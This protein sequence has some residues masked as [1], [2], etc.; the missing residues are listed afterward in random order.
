MTLSWKITAFALPLWLAGQSLEA[1]LL[2]PHFVTPDF[3]TNQ[4]EYEHWE[5]S[6]WDKFY[7]PHD[8]N[9]TKPQNRNYPDIAAPNGYAVEHV[10]SDDIGPLG[11]VD[12]V[13]PGQYAYVGPF[14]GEYIWTVQSHAEATASGYTG[15]LPTNLNPS[16][17]RTIFHADN[18]SIRQHSSA[19]FIIGPGY[20]GNIYS[21]S[22]LV[23]YTLED[24]LSY[25]A[26][27][28]VFQ[29]Q[30]QG[31]D[32]DMDS[33]RLRYNDGTGMV[34]VPAT[35]LIIEREAFASHAGFTFTTR[36]AA[37]WN[38]SALGITNY[39][40]V[41][42]AAGTSCS[43]QECL[44][45]TADVY[46]RDKGLPAK[47]IFAGTGGSS[48]D[49]G[50]NW[51]DVAGNQ[52]P[53][54][55]GAN[56]VLQGGTML[57][58]G[59]TT[60]RVSLLETD[61]PGNF[62]V[63]GA[64][65]I[66]LGTGFHANGSSTTKFVSFDVPVQMT[67]FNYFD[68]GANVTVA[69]N[70]E[71]SGNTGFE[72]R[73]AGN[74][75]LAGNNTF[76]GALFVSG[77]RLTV[78]GNNV[79]GGGELDMTYIYLGELVLEGG[80]VM[81]NNGVHVAIGSTPYEI[82]GEATPS[83]LVVKGERTFVNPIDFTGGYNP[84]LLTFT[85]TG[86]GAVC[87]APVTLHDGTELGM[88]GT[89][90][91]TGEFWLDTPLATDKVTFAGTFTG[92][93]T[94]TGTPSPHALHKTGPGTVVFSGG[95]KSHKHKTSVEQGTLRLE[96]GTAINSGNGVSVSAGATFTANGNV[97]LTGSTLLVDGLL[98]GSGAL[99]RTGGVVVSGGGTIAK[100][101]TIDAG[102]TLSP[103]NGIGKL[104]LVGNQTW[105]AAGRL[106]LEVGGID[107]AL[108][109]RLEIQGALAVTDTS[110][111]PFTIELQ[112]LNLLSTAG[113]VADFNS[114]GH[115][116]WTLCSASSGITGFNAAAFTVNTTG[117]AHT[118]AGTFAVEQRVNDIVLV[119]TP[120]SMPSP[121]Y[122]AWAA[123]LPAGVRG[124]N[125]DADH[126]GLSNL[127][128]FALGTSGAVADG[129]GSPLR[130]R[131]ETTGG[132]GQS[133]L[134]FTR[135]E[136]FRPGVTVKLLASSTLAPGNWQT[137]ATKSGLSAWQ[138]T[139]ET[140]E[141]TTAAGRKPVTI[142]VADTTPDGAK[143]FFRLQFRNEE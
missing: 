82:P 115:H 132:V 77:G 23:S 95:N 114:Y 113:P 25:N 103:G 1:Q 92:G 60:R 24:S 76:T 98:D 50:V 101:L 143:R 93:A 107:P 139:G 3:S 42:K 16:L 52:S 2:R 136:P 38:V 110:G 108:H 37:E 116:A 51:R 118:L 104:T 112:S 34:E 91:P 123:S 111:T 71:F 30:N 31:R 48:W 120:S 7:T 12:Q 35:D 53:P 18:P 100:P 96:S 69:L 22:S 49:A 74:L 106:R 86:A 79:Y 88:F 80:G 85:A 46:V 137:I 128:E 15:L 57:D 14:N 84:K 63:Q 58:V 59:S 72:K 11:D 17:P 56:I 99:V 134:E 54:L 33:L 75:A 121:S 44:L 142:K 64:S 89:E 6:R 62:T 40:L 36:A 26:G 83:S 27:A 135:V 78:S 109:D 9:K 5:Y 21:F 20:T 67:A 133:V 124:E 141:G 8:L 10:G 4:P 127:T 125:D 117:F 81:G 97:S 87:S 28:V 39:E 119:Y 130:I 13:S 41:W 55:D 122:A 102:T 129:S 126:D 47:R 43:I 73:G 68:V 94:I 131:R 65:P 45:D 140:T 70:Q 105:G 29:F 90:T 61:L 19:A 32:V 138:G 66:E